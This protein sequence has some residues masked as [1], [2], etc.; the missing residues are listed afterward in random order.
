MARIENHWTKYF[1]LSSVG[2]RCVSAIDTK[3]AAYIYILFA[4]IEVLHAQYKLLY[5]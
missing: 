4:F 5:F 1:V 2:L 3:I